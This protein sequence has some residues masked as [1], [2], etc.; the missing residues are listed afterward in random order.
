[1]GTRADTIPTSHAKLGA[2]SEDTATVGWIEADTGELKSQ[3]MGPNDIL[4]RG[5][6][7]NE[8]VIKD[9]RNPIVRS[10]RA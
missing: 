1:M 8:V 2:M 5:T 7:E 4:G 10:A 6:F 3:P 9:A